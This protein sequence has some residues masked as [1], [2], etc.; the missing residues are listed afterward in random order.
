MIH[1]NWGTIKYELKAD[2]LFVSKEGIDH[3]IRKTF[4]VTY[5]APIISNFFKEI[6]SSPIDKREQSGELY[7]VS[8]LC[9]CLGFDVNQLM[10]D[11]GF[12]LCYDDEEVTDKERIDNKGANV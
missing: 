4:G 2:K 10:N 7:R 1:Y 9:D 6:E 11:E 8:Q 3:F 12:W 5:N